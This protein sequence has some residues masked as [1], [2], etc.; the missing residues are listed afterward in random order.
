MFLSSKR[1][2]EA[3][4]FASE[5]LQKFFCHDVQR[6]DYYC[7]VWHRTRE[8]AAQLDSHFGGATFSDNVAAFTE[9]FLMWLEE[10][11]AE[12]LLPWIMREHV[13][14]DK[15]STPFEFLNLTKDWLEEFG[16]AEASTKPYLS[17]LQGPEKIKRFAQFVARESI[18]EEKWNLLFQRKGKHLDLQGFVSWLI[19][20]P[21]EKTLYVVYDEEKI[22]SSTQDKKLAA[23]RFQKVFLHELGHARLNFDYVLGAEGQ[24]PLPAHEVESWLYAS[25]IRGLILGTRARVCRLLDKAIDDEW[26]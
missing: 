3:V 11:K 15:K 6:S 7:S 8:E 14:L 16:V 5:D 25:A 18:S 26:R 23:Q 13:T 19:V 1:N 12:A 21:E 10:R 2:I 4:N 9:S 24:A 17:H 20:Y 22:N